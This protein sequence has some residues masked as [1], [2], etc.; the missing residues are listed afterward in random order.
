MLL[1]YILALNLLGFPS[2]LWLQKFGICAFHVEVFGS[3][4]LKMEEPQEEERYKVDIQE[5]IT[6]SFDNK[7]PVLISSSLVA[8]DRDT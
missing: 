5:C 2:R 1:L 6:I 8:K 3:E 4:D 7:P